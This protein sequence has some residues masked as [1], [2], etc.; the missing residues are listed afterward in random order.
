MPKRSNQFQKLIRDINSKLSSDRVLITESKLLVDS[1]TG[2]EREVDIYIEDFAGPYRVKVS[3]ECTAKAR[4]LDRPAVEQL[5]A[6][7]DG[8]DTS[9]LVIVSKSGFSK[10]CYPYAKKNNIELIEFND[11]ESMDWPNW[12]EKLKGLSLIHYK[13]RAIEKYLTL[14]SELPEEF[15]SKSVWVKSSEFGSIPIDDYI[16]FRCSHQAKSEAPTTGV[17]EVKLVFDPPLPVNDVNGLEAQCIAMNVKYL[18]SNS[19]IDLDMKYR[20][21]RGSPIAYGVNDNSDLGRVSFIASSHNSENKNGK[22]DLSIS[23]DTKNT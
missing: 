22:F 12:M 7:H 16:Y 20:E 18:E 6:K 21:Y 4:K 13:F 3:I 14:K 19:D 1:Y 8:L 5:K 2:D 17:G 10:T 11:A 15:D 23:I 9:H